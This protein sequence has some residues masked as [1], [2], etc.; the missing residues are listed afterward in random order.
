VRERGRE[1]KKES[2]GKRGREKK[3][4]REGKRER[5]GEGKRE[6]ERGRGGRK[7]EEGRL[8][9]PAYLSTCLL[10]YL[11]PSPPFSLILGP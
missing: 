7:T 3:G 4:V 2:E 11:P 5:K 8:L 6:R 1:R 9:I 10:L